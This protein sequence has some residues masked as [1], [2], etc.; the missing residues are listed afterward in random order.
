MN[1]KRLL[2]LISASLFFCLLGFKI[3]PNSNPLQGTNSLFFGGEN[4]VVDI[5][6]CSMDNSS[7]GKTRAIAPSQRKSQVVLGVINLNSII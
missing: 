2:Q 7:G 4:I 6:D 1:S 5:I 3:V